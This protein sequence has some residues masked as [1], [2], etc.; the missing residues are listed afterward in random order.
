MNK[1]NNIMLYSF[2]GPVY[3]LSKVKVMYTLANHYQAIEMCKDHGLWTNRVKLKAWLQRSTIYLLWLL[4]TRS[5]D[6]G[7]ITSPV[8]HFCHLVNVHNIYNT[9]LLRGGKDKENIEK[10]T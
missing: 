3:A 8:S 10:H 5:P 2:S 9:E 6:L 7:N 1:S 4:N